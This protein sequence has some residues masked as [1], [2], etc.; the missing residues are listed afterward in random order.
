[1][2]SIQCKPLS[3][4]SITGRFRT[5]VDTEIYNAN[6]QAGVFALTIVD[7]H[8]VLT[9]ITKERKQ[10]LD[11]EDATTVTDG[12]WHSFAVT[13]G[14]EG[15]HFYLDGYLA[16]CGTSTAFLADLNASE[17]NIAQG[18]I[19]IED[20]T[21]HEKVLSTEEVL[22]YALPAVPLIQFAGNRLS[23][24]DT[25]QVSTLISGTTYTRFRVRGIGQGGTILSAGSNS[26]EGLRIT[27]DATELTYEVLTAENTW[28]IWR[29]S[30][31]WADGDWHD[32]VIRAG[33]GAVDIY[34][35]GYRE[36]RIPGQ[37]FFGDL[38]SVDKIMIGQD[39]YGTRLFGE[40]S[41]AAIYKTPLTEGQIKRLSHVKPLCTRALFDRGLE[42]SISYRIPSIITLPSGTVIAGADQRTTIANDS[43][44]D[45]NFVIRRSEDGGK[46]W[47][48]LV[49]VLD[50]PGEAG[51][52]ASV[53]DSCLV[54]DGET[55]TLHCMIDHFPGGIG[56]PNNEHGVGMDE[57]G[58]LLVT[59]QE[60]NEYAINN[61]GSVVTKDN[62]KTDYRVDRDG[63]VFKAEKPRGNIYLKDGVDP[64]QS[65]LTARTS[66]LVHIYS[67]DEGLTWS[68]PH[69]INSQV[70]EP[71]MAFLGTSPGTGI[72]L[73]HGSYAGRLVV[74]VYYSGDVTKCFSAAVI[75]SD[76]HGKTWKRGASP[77]DGRVYGNETLDSRSLSNDEA[78]THESTLLELSDGSLMVLMRNQHPSGRVAQSI[79]H[80][81][82]E[83]WGEVSYNSD[84]TEI[85]SQPNAIKIPSENGESAFVFANASQLMPYRGNGVLRISTDEGK[86][87]KKHRTFNPG[88]YVYQSMTWLPDGQIGLL[89]ENEWQGLY[90]TRIPM[91]WFAKN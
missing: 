15:T 52:G 22:A 2:T 20:V 41:K 51:D 75:Y 67:K 4:G 18:A 72:Q 5:T 80:D 24:Y 7:D 21:I 10:T 8:P 59:D 63:S 32:V 60:G 87:W 17:L 74:P 53:I 29:T 54:Y 14:E 65:L 78:S 76:D 25:R 38:P 37:A 79:S 64:K 68:E 34:V 23:E 55:E 62:K 66:Y 61:D 71:W 70:K 46:T 44:N 45:I 39:I 84:L 30:G 83:T 26:L 12:M 19:D 81:G 56:Q 77:N 36:A 49:T 1:M 3:K 27:I 69:F 89:W 82:G 73:K 90:F 50:Y 13:V 31:D 48:D 43:P 40:V 33:E 57:Q 91:S 58:R 16:F 86:T 11:V 47:G 9:T 35:D 6:T 28:R 42:G 88:H 85:F